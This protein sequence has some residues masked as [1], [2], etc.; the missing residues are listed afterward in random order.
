MRRTGP[1]FYVEADGEN[2]VMLTIVD[3]QGH[4]ESFSTTTPAEALLSMVAVDY[5]ALRD[6][7]WRL[8]CEYPLDSCD[9]EEQKAEKAY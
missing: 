2:A 9:R 7:V 8:W 6:E 1:A 4:E 5:T 3:A